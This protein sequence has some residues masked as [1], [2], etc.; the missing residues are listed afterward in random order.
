[1]VSQSTS[2]WLSTLKIYCYLNT[3]PHWCL[4]PCLALLYFSLIMF[5]LPPRGT[6]PSLTLSW[7][8]FHSFPS[9]LPFDSD[10]CSFSY[11][12]AVVRRGLRWLDQRKQ[13]D[14]VGENK[15]GPIEKVCPLISMTFLL[16]LTW[17]YFYF[18]NWNIFENNTI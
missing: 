8:Y 11:N 10:L 5:S 14:K 1:M 3:D 15:S 2:Q 12:S 4:C 9:E 7:K 18:S 17:F 13:G 6:L 16:N